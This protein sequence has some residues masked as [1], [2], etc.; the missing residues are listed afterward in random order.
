MTTNANEMK[1][2]AR[3]Q[4]WTAAIQEC[5]SSGQSVRKWCKEQ[6]IATGN[7]LPLVARS[8]AYDKTVAERAATLREWKE[9]TLAYYAA[10]AVQCKEL[11]ELD[12]DTGYP[13]ESGL[14]SV[15]VVSEDGMLADGRS[16]ACYVMGLEESITY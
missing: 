15:T 11:E 14:I 4:E 7:L 1:H 10:T 5:R 9:Q 8:T 2:Q 16:T 12:P 13:A 6:G 3:L